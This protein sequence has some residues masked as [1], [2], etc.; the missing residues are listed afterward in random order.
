MMF[1]NYYLLLLSFGLAMQS[2]SGDG[3]S[4]S[5]SD[6]T[7]QY[8]HIPPALPDSV[9]NNLRPGDIIIRKGNGPL[10][11]HIMVN[12]KEEYS[13]CG[14]IVKEGN[15]WK[16]IHTIGGSASEDA[17]DGVQMM[18]L[19]EFVKHGADSM[20]FICRPVFADSLDIK[21]PERAYAYLE[22]AVPFDHAFSL[23][24]PEKLYCSELLFYIFKEVNG[25][26]N[27]FEVKKQHKSYMLLFSTFFDTQK[28]LPVFHLREDNRTPGWSGWTNTT[29]SSDTLLQQTALD[30]AGVH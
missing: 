2:C 12:T 21:I 22:K 25:G 8:V 5:G 19:K 10:S 18:D 29:A 27:V 6:S 16:V 14:I 20:L 17:Q 13:H 30:T 3:E 23:F 9:Y 15:E 26:E 1:R 4:Q 28:F 11:A 7:K 24:T